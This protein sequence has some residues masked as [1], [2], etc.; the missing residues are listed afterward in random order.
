MVLIFFIVITLVSKTKWFNRMI[1][2]LT[3]AVKKIV[4]RRGNHG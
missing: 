1:T 2:G 4:H 3:Q